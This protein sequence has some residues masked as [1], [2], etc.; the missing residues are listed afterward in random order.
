MTDEAGEVSSALT[1]ILSETEE[2]GTYLVRLL[3]DQDWLLSEERVYPVA[4][5][6]SIALAYSGYYTMQNATL[7]SVD[8]TANL[9]GYG[10]MYIGR[11]SSMENVRGA[12]KIQ[13]LPVI[14]ES[15]MIIQAAVSFKVRSYSQLA[16]SHGGTVVMNMF[17]LTSEVAISA[18]NWGNLANYMGDYV[19][20]TQS[21]EP[22]EAANIKPRITW[23]ITRAVKTWYNDG[24]NYGMVIASENES[25]T[26]VRYVQLTTATNS[27]YI[28]EN[29]PIF[30][31]TYLN[32]E[33]LESYLTYHSSGS[34]T[35]GAIHVGDFNGNLVYTYSDLDMSGAY[36]PISISHVYNHS[37]RGTSALVG[38]G[39]YF[40]NGM[41]LNLS[42][43]IESCSVNGY[44]YQLTDADG[45]VHYFSLKSGTAGAVGS[46]YEKEF[47]STTVLTK[48]STG[49]TLD[50][51]GTIQYYFNTNGYLTQLSDITNSK[52]QTL[53]YTNGRLTK[54]TDGAGREVTLSYNGSGYL[55]GITD[56]AGRTTGYAYTNGNLTTIT[57]P[58]G[59]T[60]T[61]T[62]TLTDGTYM[63]TKVT[64]VDGRSIGITYDTHAPYRVKQLLEFGA[65]NSEGQRL[66][67]TYSE[68]ETTVTDRQGRSETMLF[69]NSG[70]TVATRDGEGHAVYG[71]YGETDDNL[72]HSLLYLSKMRG[73]VR[74]L[75]LNHSFET[76][77]YSQWI[78]YSSGSGSLTVDTSTVKEGTKSLKIVNNDSNKYYGVYQEQ[79][80][81]G[82]AG[83]TYTVSGYVYLEN[84]S[85]VG[86]KGFRP[87]FWYKDT[88]NHWVAIYGR[89]L[90]YQ[91]GWTRFSLTCT[92]PENI[93]QE[94]LDY[95]F[96]MTNPGTCYIDCIQLVE[97][98]VSESYNM[99]EN[100]HFKDAAGTVTPSKW[101]VISSSTG[102]GVTTGHNGNGYGLNGEATVNKG[103]YQVV[104][105]GNGQAGDNYVFGAWAKAESVPRIGL[106]KNDNR[107]FAVRIR[108]IKADNTY[109]ES[110]FNFEAKTPNWQ[111]LS[112]SAVAPCP[113]VSIQYALIYNN[114]KNPVVFDDAELFRERFGDR[115][116][117][118][119]QGRI[120]KRTDPDGLETTYE[121]QWSGRPEIKKV[122]FPDGTSTNYS[123]NSSNRRL[124]TVTDASGKVLT[125]NYDTNGNATSVS[126][127]AG[128]QTMSS[129][130]TA[131]SGSY[132]SS[133]TDPFGNITSF[134]YNQNRGLLNSSTNANNDTTSYTYNTNNDQLTQVQTASSKVQ[135]GYTNT[136]LVSLTH[137]TTT[138]SSGNVVYNLTYNT[139]GTQTAVKVGTQSLASYTYAA[140]NG[141]L[142][143]TTYGNGQ[144]SEP[145]YDSLGRII[146]MS[147]NG[148]VGY[149]YYYG[150]DG[151]IG[152]EEDLINNISWRYEYDQSGKLLAVSGSNGESFVYEYSSTTGELTG[153]TFYNAANPTGIHDTYTY[154]NY[155]GTG[156]RI[157]SQISRDGG[158]ATI[159]YTYNGFYR[160]TKTTK[161]NAGASVTS[162][163]TFR[164]GTA[165]NSTS[166]VPASITQT[167]K[168]NGGSTVS[169]I[170][171]NYTYDSLGNIETISEGSTLKVK[172]YYDSLNQLTRENNVYLNKT[173]T[174]SYDLG[175]NLTSVK[176]YAY[177]TGAT[178][179]GTPTVINSY[180]YED[181][182]WKDKL[183]KYNGTTITYDQIGNPLT[184][185]NG[186]SFTWTQGRRLASASNGTN[187]ISYAYNNDGI[188][189]SKTVNGVTTSY[190]LDGTK[191]IKETTGSDTIWYYYDESGAPVVFRLNSTLYLYTKN[192]QGDITGIRNTAGTLL[193]SYVYDAWG[194]VTATN[195]AGNTEGTNLIAKN[196]Y[197]YR[198]YR[199]DAETS[200]YY[201][202]SRYYDPQTG[203]FINA[204]VFVST[205]QDIS[206]TNMFIYCGNN[207]T[208]RADDIGEWWHI[209]V[210][211]IVGVV[212]QYVADVTQNLTEGKSFIESLVPTSSVV[213]YGAAALSGG[214][215]A[216]G[217][218]F[219][220][221]IAVNAAI[222]GATYLANCAL[223][224]ETPD[225]VD[226][227]I[228][229]TIGGV[230][231]AIGGKGAD[232]KKLIGITEVSKDVLNNST[233]AKK[234]A[235]Y[236]A[237]ITACKKKAVESGLRTIGAG[238]FSNTVNNKYK[239][240]ILG[241]EY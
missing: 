36:L 23:D 55:T 215:A 5:D 67:W 62:Y 1:L 115:L 195:V 163:Y 162:S 19:I 11:Q 35:M 97:G 100:G 126:T 155:S 139:F 145:T 164:P 123:Y 26:T 72:K 219:G 201:L 110:V 217:I 40:G 18:L 83:K 96:T 147:Y 196:P 3:P 128:G 152:L 32:Q 135:Y 53:T 144:Y 168:N 138:S 202:N 175:G 187:T 206:S 192:L 122:T 208:C 134:S 52:T 121:Y 93:G 218:G 232:G 8:P 188:R 43:R 136:R 9:Y 130:T 146:A 20:D 131:Y 185:Y 64:D 31:L 38:S 66:T 198:G 148:T 80:V 200:L 149:R 165:S 14:G 207:P 13:N 46:T 92:I 6:P 132:V 44:P 193:V 226:L 236:T 117:Y 108:F 223:E 12:Y 209:L 234:V 48:T 79:T 235:M 133:V 29:S 191:V 91:S 70:H 160:A 30:T 76:G 157:L 210:G 181:S 63:L 213:D 214:L 230:S 190:T 166:V 179:S 57:R 21:V 45:T 106:F 86:T 102:D 59:L 186:Y 84:Y 204:D 74:N 107:D 101:T 238:L 240:I 224:D 103:I 194:K 216:T 78:S 124:L 54:V 56:P 125:Y 154:A 177:Q 237:K 178:V 51:G 105:V 158:N 197:L 10:S 87:I 16:S 228:A 99:L 153:Q 88:T 180:T 25:P 39:M 50:D 4:I 120:I 127:T 239:K 114:Q 189:I 169:S 142:T 151:R 65:N 22:D 156:E 225:V 184:Y 113:Y 161:L 141:E 71:G 27:Q 140:N 150:S 167:V 90:P 42:L 143:C 58:D 183:T 172:Y 60:V 173:I 61:L 159:S 68:G 205:G 118:D 2:P 203:R 241:S 109:E 77:T 170:T 15:D 129:G 7:A 182:N 98:A 212:T 176:E 112:G 49:Y 94:K 174:Y 119:D 199:Y 111:Y 116:D 85:S 221:S 229:T 24:T 17:P 222:G 104:P 137:N 231:G 69:D 41:R 227:A 220:T 95:G 81:P 75:A 34:G 37:R 47:E 28:N 89:Y 82:M 171:Y 233:S 211:A 33:G 73:S